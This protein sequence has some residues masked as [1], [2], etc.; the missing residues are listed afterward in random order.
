MVFQ[1]MEK[2]NKSDKSF[3]PSP[4]L[5]LSFLILAQEESYFSRK[6]SVRFSLK[7]PMGE[8]SFLPTSIESYSCPL[9]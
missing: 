5:F 7:I 6:F 8:F 1:Q 4:N 2:S 3:S 9:R